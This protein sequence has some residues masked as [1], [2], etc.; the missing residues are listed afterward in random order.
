M[1]F[2]VLTRGDASPRS[3]R[4]TPGSIGTALSLLLS[5]AKLARVPTAMIFPGDEARGNRLKRAMRP[6]RV[7]T[8][9]AKAVEF[10]FGVVLK[11]HIPCENPNRANPPSTTAGDNLAARRIDNIPQH[12]IIPNTV[13]QA[14]MTPSPVIPDP[15]PPS[16]RYTNCGP[17]G[18]RG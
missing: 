6:S 10:W 18:N 14:D 11:Y 16:W 17:N 13:D 1:I 7:N 12:A 3:N 15:T 5:I 4:Y 8:C 9:N 2:L